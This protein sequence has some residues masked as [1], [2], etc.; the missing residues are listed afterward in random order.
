M[1]KLVTIWFFLILVLLPGC[2]NSGLLE[3]A[4]E[5]Y[6]TS[7]DHQS[8]KIIFGKLSKGMSRKNV[9]KLLGEPG[10][11]P[12]EGQHY[13]LCN[14]KESPNGGIDNEQIPIGVVVDYRDQSGELTN[15]LQ[16]FWIGPIGE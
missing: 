13:Y 6:K 4:S 5:T 14:K 9:E 16:D 15:K 11:S 7:H 12:T 2:A 1:A 8:L 10:Y 3:Q